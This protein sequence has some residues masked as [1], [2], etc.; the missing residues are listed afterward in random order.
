MNAND[1]LVPTT[2]DDGVGIEISTHVSFAPSCQQYRKSLLRL[3]NPIQNAYD[4]I[5]PISQRETKTGT[6]ETETKTAAFPS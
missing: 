4:Y 2:M 6:T 5:N 1:F 3:I